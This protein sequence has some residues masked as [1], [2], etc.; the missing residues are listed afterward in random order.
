MHSE[1]LLATGSARFAELLGPSN[2]F[3]TQRRRKMVNKMPEGVR[4]VI[5]LTPADEGEDLVFQMTEL[6]LTPGIRKWWMAAKLHKVDK[7]LVTGHDDICE[8]TLGPRRESS[9]APQP[10]AAKEC[11]PD[12]LNSEPMQKLLGK[13]FIKVRS[14]TQAHIRGL[15]ASMSGDGW[16][17]PTP[18]LLLSLKSADVSLSPYIPAFRKAP[19]Y[20]P[21]RHRNSIVRLL[22]MMEGKTIVLNSASRVWTM[23]GIAKVFDCPMVMRDKVAQWILHGDNSKFIEVLPEE[24]LKIGYTLELPQITQGAFRILVNE[25]AIDLESTSRPSEW[26]AASITAFG[27][28]RGDAGDELNN[29]IQHAAQAL[30]DRIRGF[31]ASL[32]DFGIVRNVPEVKRL[33][34]FEDFLIQQ[35]EDPAAEMALQKLHVLTDSLVPAIQE[36][37]TEALTPS[38][39]ALDALV[40]HTKDCA[41]IDRDRATY[42]E[43]E[44]FDTTLDI[45]FRF[46][47]TQRLLCGLTY[48]HFSDKCQQLFYGTTM[49]RLPG[50]SSK[51]MNTLIDEF[52]QTFK[53][54]CDAAED[55]VFDLMIG[56]EPWKGLSRIK[57]PAIDIQR[58]KL[59]ISDAMK[60]FLDSY[61]RHTISPP[62]NLT[63]HLL[64]TLS[65]DEMK[66]LPLWA[67]GCNDGTGGVFQDFVP[68]TDMGPNG[69]GPS[70]HT[71]NTVPSAG[72]TISDSFMDG[73]RGLHVMGSTTAGSVDVHDS[74]STVYRQDQVIAED[75]S[76]ASESFTPDDPDYSD[77]RFAI[78][79]DHQRQGQAVRKLVESE[80]EALSASHAADANVDVKKLT[81][82][83]WEV[84]DGSDTGSD[85]A[86]DTSMVRIG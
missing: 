60:P 1:R 17:P 15:T 54:A 13:C 24:A 27:R 81:S 55:G 85:T 66:Y 61:L 44:N 69:P 8:C 11:D 32:I 73:I 80:S 71:G 64:L 21:I 56:P 48:R 28:K 35:R 26:K 67:G 83:D 34:K 49:V 46:N 58:L 79:A 6:S 82:D 45:M 12:V 52:T 75:H 78:P 39:A 53:V 23:I 25:L 74:I 3:R 84:D 2:Q 43:P 42:V 14:K 38:S 50:Q 76:I 33:Q 72:S 4:F 57:R 20:C 31:E 62:L 10:E 37:L 68:T 7:S 77:A 70:F 51:R 86:S 18:E 40:Q 41:S 30:C 47:T 5:D 63:R 36:R 22:A 16:E 59:E 29:L 65:T 9:T 19:D